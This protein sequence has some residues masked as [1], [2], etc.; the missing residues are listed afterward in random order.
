MVTYVP[1]K[2]RK[3]DAKSNGF[4]KT[5]HYFFN[6]DYSGRKMGLDVSLR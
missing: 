1:E 4:G 3:I 5:D 6:M 2:S